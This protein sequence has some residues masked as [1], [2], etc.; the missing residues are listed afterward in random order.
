MIPQNATII[1]EEWFREAA[2]AKTIAARYVQ[3]LGPPPFYLEAEMRY[4]PAW[5]RVFGLV[6]GIGLLLFYIA[7]LLPNERANFTLGRFML[8][9]LSFGCWYLTVRLVAYWGAWGFT[10]QKYQVIGTVHPASRGELP[11]NWYIFVKLA[12]SVALI[13]L[14][15]PLYLVGIVLGS[16]VWLAIAVIAGT[17]IRDCKTVWQLMR[18]NR[19]SWILQTRFGLDVLRPIDSSQVREFQRTQQRKPPSLHVSHESYATHRYL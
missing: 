11:K 17:V 18:V 12:P 2:P 4:S 8:I 5:S 15:V 3:P 6:A 14:L 10:A 1:Q 9:P 7:F 13:S 19:G 16:E